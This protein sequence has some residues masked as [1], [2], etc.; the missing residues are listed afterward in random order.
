MTDERPIPVW[1][2]RNVGTAWLPFAADAPIDRIAVCVSDSEAKGLLTSADFAAK[3]G[4]TPVRLDA[5]KD[6][7]DQCNVLVL[8]SL[9]DESKSVQSPFNIADADWIRS[10]WNVMFKFWGDPNMTSDDVVKEL[11]SQYDT[12]FG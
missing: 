7:L 5:A 6:G 9:K 4:S 8:D 2:W 1:S 10:V 3:K 12:I 11:K